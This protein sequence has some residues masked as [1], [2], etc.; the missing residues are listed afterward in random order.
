MNNLM[1]GV[2]SRLFTI[3]FKKENEVTYW[4]NKWGITPARLKM[5]GRRSVNNTVAAV[6]N[7]LIQLG[8][9]EVGF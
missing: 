1:T 2:F 4:A 6:Y 8:Y 5:A 3:N 9:L 7:T